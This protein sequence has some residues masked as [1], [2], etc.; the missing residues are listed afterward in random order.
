MAGLGFSETSLSSSAIE[1]RDKLAAWV[2]T[3]IFAPIKVTYQGKDVKG[4]L[5]CE[6]AEKDAKLRLV[7]TAMVIRKSMKCDR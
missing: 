4:I 1:E 6:D 2:G 3:A 7:L 5:R